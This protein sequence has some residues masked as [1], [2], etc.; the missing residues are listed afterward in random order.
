[1]TRR[2]VQRSDRV[3]GER[4]RDLL[5][6]VERLL[7]AALHPRL[8]DRVAD[9]LDAALHEGP[10]RRLPLTLDER[11][12]VDRRVVLGD[13]R[14]ALVELGRDDLL[15]RDDLAIRPVERDLEALRGLHH[16]APRPTDPEVDL[17]A[18]DLAALARPP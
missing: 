17:D 16:V 3:S 18:R 8:D 5:E 12:R 11:H 13:A 6:R 1:M 10:Q 9:L 2:L 7:H 15:V 14:R 4:A